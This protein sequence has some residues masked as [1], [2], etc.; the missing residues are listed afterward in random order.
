MD[1]PQHD[2]LFPADW[3]ALPD[4]PG[5]THSIVETP[6]LRTHLAEIGEGDPV[7]LLHGCPEHWWQWETVAPLVAARGYRVL[8]P[9]LRGAG[10]T[11]AA[12]EHMDRE[13]RLQD[14]LAI[15]DE[16]GIARAHLLSHD[17]GAL[18]A[19]Q[20][21]YEHP[22]RV[23]RAVQ[24]SVPPAFMAFSL[25][26]L[27]G[28]KHLPAFLFHRPGASL[29]GT[30][31]SEYAARPLP[32]AVIDAHLAPLRRPEID[33]AIRSAS[34]RLIVPEGLRMTA[35]LYRRRRLTVPTRF[36]Y[37][38]EDRFWNE[39]IMRRICRHPERYAD[40][41]DFAYVDGASHFMTDDAPGAVADVA[42]E[43]IEQD[44]G[45]PTGGPEAIRWG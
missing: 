38:R 34:R 15:L 3:P 25:R 9:D 45:A 6:G 36:V 8:C 2:T 31:S 40:R 30:F 1:T 10:W 18:T 20:L 11:A 26:T 35:G 17:L 23:R 28:F 13:T 24:L 32:D 21:S 33:R 37:G 29:R 16:L 44:A 4:A 22:E 5:F 7:L 41:V 43:W 14:I 19:M 12:D 42:L 39:A 27:P